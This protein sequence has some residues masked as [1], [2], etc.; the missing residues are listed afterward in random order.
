[1]DAERDDL[2]QKAPKGKE[3]GIV[4]KCVL[5]HEHLIARDRDYF[6]VWAKVYPYGALETARTVVI[7]RKR[8]AVNG[9]AICSSV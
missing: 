9:N 1:M 4:V 5:G 7:L 3:Y 6:R 2:S 8:E